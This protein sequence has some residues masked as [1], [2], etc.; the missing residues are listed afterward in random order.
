MTILK[1]IIKCVEVCTKVGDIC[2]KK[3][4]SETTPASRHQWCKGGQRPLLPPRH[5]WCYF[6]LFHL[7]S[8]S[9]F[10]LCMVCAICESI[11]CLKYI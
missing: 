7:S 10:M 6:P 9:I 1:E 4:G 5:Q 3:R 8:E 11:G 2:L